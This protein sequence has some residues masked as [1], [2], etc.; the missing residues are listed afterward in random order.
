MDRLAASAEINLRSAASRRYYAVY[1]RA[2]I[3]LFNNRDGWQPDTNSSVHTQVWSQFGGQ[4]LIRV[5]N[6]GFTAVQRRGNADYDVDLPF[7]REDFD[8]VTEDCRVIHGIL[9]GLEGNA[10]EGR[11][12]SPRQ[13]R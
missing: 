1:H 3:W 11:P 5:R 2:R 4:F 10:A 9:D 6:R 12:S 13:N 8:K 7:T